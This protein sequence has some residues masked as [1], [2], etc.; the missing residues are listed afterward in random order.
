V[1]SREERWSVPVPTDW[2]ME[3]FS[4]DYVWLSN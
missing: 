1:R 3:I 2:G 4:R